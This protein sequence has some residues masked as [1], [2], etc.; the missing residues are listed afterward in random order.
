LS[1][2]GTARSRIA[3]G[4]LARDLEAERRQHVVGLQ[5]RRRRFA[6]LDRDREQQ[7]LPRHLAARVRGPQARVRDP[8]VG[9]VLVD[10]DQ[11]VGRLAH[12]VGAVHLAD[13]V[14][15][16]EELLP[17][18]RRRVVERVGRGAGHPRRRARA[19][20]GRPAPAREQRHRARR[21]RAPARVAAAPAVSKRAAG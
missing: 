3:F 1:G 5:R 21:R 2:S 10:Q 17:L 16:R 4:P 18:P 15:A 6:D 7:L 19:R 20:A 8:F 12:Q 9:G 14:Q 13:V 11:L